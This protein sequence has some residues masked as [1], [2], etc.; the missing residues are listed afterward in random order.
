MTFLRSVTYVAAV[1]V[2]V[3]HIVASVVLVKKTCK[4]ST[5]V[6]PYAALSL[7]RFS[8]WWDGCGD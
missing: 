5:R 8:L 2:S 6:W 4:V 1:V 3:E 7:C